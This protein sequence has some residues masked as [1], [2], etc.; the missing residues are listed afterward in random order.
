MYILI[1]QDNFVDFWIT[2]LH[3]DCHRL[4]IMN[5]INNTALN[6]HT[7]LLSATL[8]YAQIISSNFTC[9]C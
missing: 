4:L 9:R 7:D 8:R 5:M 6:L 2:N 3:H 1:I